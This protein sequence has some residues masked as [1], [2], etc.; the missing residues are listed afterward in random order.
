MKGSF[1]A[2]TM[3]SYEA[4]QGT[5]TLFFSAASTH[6]LSTGQTSTAL[7]ATGKFSTHLWP[8]NGKGKQEDPVRLVKSSLLAGTL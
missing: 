7:S 4:V 6:V 3:V 1:C 2:A 5:G 8:Q